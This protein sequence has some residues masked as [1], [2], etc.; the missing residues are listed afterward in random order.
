MKYLEGIR[1]IPVGRLKF[2]DECHFTTR[3]T[4]LSGLFF[5]MGNLILD[6]FCTQYLTKYL[7]LRP[8]K[9]LS[10]IGT[11]AVLTFH[12]GIAAAGSITLMTSLTSNPPFYASYRQD[13]NTQT[14]FVQFL[15]DCVNNGYLGEGDVL[16]MDNARVHTG[17]TEWDNIRLLQDLVGFE[18]MT[19]PTYSPELNP[20]ELV[21]AAVKN[22]LRS[23][24]ATKNGVYQLLLP[25]KVALGL[26]MIP[27]ENFQKFYLRCF[28]PQQW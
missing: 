14:D 12:G 18:I 20:C 21:F 17:A 28:Y 11:P 9:A 7:D 19:L 25:D 23:D 13:S 27:H 5:L 8:R 16:V 1:R 3:G 22:F 24:Q 15:R 4:P 6:E 26:A 10:P 2:L